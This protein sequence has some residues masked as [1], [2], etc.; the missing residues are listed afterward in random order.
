MKL[1]DPATARVMK[2][3]HGREVR[4]FVHQKNQTPELKCID[5]LSITAIEIGLKLSR[6]RL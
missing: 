1:G 2:E 3:L 6:R 5:R 4:G